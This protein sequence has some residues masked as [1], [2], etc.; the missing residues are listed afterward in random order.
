LILWKAI[1]SF[2]IKVAIFYK[3]T[4]KEKQIHNWNFDTKLYIY[5]KNKILLQNFIEQNPED[6]I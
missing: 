3:N 1:S 4:E 6:E 2:N 5:R